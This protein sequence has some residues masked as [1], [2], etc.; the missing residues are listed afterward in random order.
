MEKIKHS[1]VQVRELKLH[2]AEIGSGGGLPAWVSRNMVHM[3]A[4][5][6]CCCKCWVPSNSHRLQ[7]LWLSEEPAEPKKATFK[8][9][10]DDVVSLLDSLGIN[11][12][13]EG[14][15]AKR[16]RDDRF[17]GETREHVELVV[18]VV[19]VVAVKAI[20]SVPATLGRRRGLLL[21]AL[22]LDEALH[23]LGRLKKIGRRKKIRRASDF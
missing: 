21:V 15:A 10:I 4:P 18:G 9:L 23:H 1:H 7:V 16:P 5:D 3:K 22:L 2:V 14:I 12:Y 11:K 19:I 17:A 8:D 13:I 20:A 6:G